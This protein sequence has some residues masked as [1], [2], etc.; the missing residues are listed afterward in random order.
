MIRPYRDTDL[1]E[2]LDAW[3]S[4]SL[5]GHPFLDD[6]F[7][8]QERI[9]IR[10]VYLP[11]AETWVFEEDRSGGRRVRSYPTH[12]S[13][14]LIK[15]WTRIGTRADTAKCPT[16]LADVRQNTKPAACS[17]KRL[18]NVFPVGRTMA[19]MA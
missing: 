9:N 15:K 7:F 18:G 12:R 3:Y 4:A 6:T 19:T 16:K 13:S 5:L 10:D 17:S 11:K 8:Q 2:L 1:N 14:I